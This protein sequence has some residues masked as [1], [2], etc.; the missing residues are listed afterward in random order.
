M[1][2]KLNADGDIDLGDNYTMKLCSLKQDLVRQRI[3]ITFGVNRGSY[4]YDLGYGTPWLTNQYNN[5]SILGKIPKVVF[6]GELK[7]QILTR[8]GVKSI[9]SFD[10]TEN[11]NTRIATTTA[12]VEIDSGEIVTISTSR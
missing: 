7:Q 4:D 1:D 9:V 2:I 11:P 3:Q 8:E 6:D 5:F 10:T 12:E